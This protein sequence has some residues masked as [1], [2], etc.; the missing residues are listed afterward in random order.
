M[1]DKRMITW[2]QA[3]AP[4]M[5]LTI[6]CFISDISF[7]KTR[8]AHALPQSFKAASSRTRSGALLRN[9]SLEAD[10]IAHDV[11]SSPKP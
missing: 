1:T 10:L 11:S 6:E 3:L 5:G 7:R 8:R 9:M 2:K 4:Q